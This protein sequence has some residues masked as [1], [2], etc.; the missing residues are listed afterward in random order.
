MGD[1]LSSLTSIDTQNLNRHLMPLP[2]LVS[3]KRE[4]FCLYLVEGFFTVGWQAKAQ[5]SP[6][7]CWQWAE[8]GGKGEGACEVQLWG[9]LFSFVLSFLYV[10]LAWFP[11][12]HPLSLWLALIRASSNLI[13]ALVPYWGSCWKE[14]GEVLIGTRF[15]LGERSPGWGVKDQ[16]RTVFEPRGWGSGL[17]AFGPTV[18]NKPGSIHMQPARKNRKLAA[19]ARNGGKVTER[20][21]GWEGAGTILPPSHLKKTFILFQRQRSF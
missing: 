13:M 7:R 20:A 18:I 21:K 4:E 14:A 2:V 12:Y 10:L 11:L 5:H 19:E 3:Q 16:N 1:Q 8:S 17:G 9:P 6:Q 15:W